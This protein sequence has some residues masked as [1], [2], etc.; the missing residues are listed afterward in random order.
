MWQYAPM[1]VPRT[2]NISLACPSSRADSPHS[3]VFGIV[4]NRGTFP[5]IRYLE[6]P[7]PATAEVLAL[8][9]GDPPNQV[10]RFTSP[11][12]NARC[13][14]FRN[15]ECSLPDLLQEHAPAAGNKHVACPIRS[16][17]RWFHQH[18]FEACARCVAIVTSEYALA[19]QELRGP[20]E[21][22]SPLITSSSTLEAPSTPIKEE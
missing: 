8:T 6:R 2:D 10:F 14:N 17:C 7:V 11:C 9:E 1:S 12:Q 22:S 21:E 13:A 15:G 4:D 5:I 16:T 19:G 3:A 20:F 18:S